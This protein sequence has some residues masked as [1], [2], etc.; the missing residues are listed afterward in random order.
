M[1]EKVSENEIVAANI[2]KMCGEDCGGEK[3]EERI[4]LLACVQ[5]V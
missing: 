5:A 4:E 2:L 3:K 1:R